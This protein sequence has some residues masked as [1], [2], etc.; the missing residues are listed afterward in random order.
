MGY[1]VR[2]SLAGCLWRLENTEPKS[3]TVVGRGSNFPD[4]RLGHIPP[5]P[6]PRHL[7]SGRVRARGKPG[8]A[9]LFLLLQAAPKRTTGLLGLLPTGKRSRALVSASLFP[10]L[11]QPQTQ[12][13]QTSWARLAKW[14]S[15]NHCLLGSQL[16]SRHFSPGLLWF[17]K[18]RSPWELGCVSGCWAGGRR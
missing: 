2:L 13:A 6:I 3:C 7:V 12:T 15:P 16:V 17:L 18:N 1:S 4:S 14:L 8:P 11:P 9:L 5:P 10:S